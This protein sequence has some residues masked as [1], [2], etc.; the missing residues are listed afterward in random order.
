[1][2]N[3]IFKFPRGSNQSSYTK[4]YVGFFLFGVIHLSGDFM[5]ARRMIYGPFKF[6]LLQPIAI[7]LEDFV[8]YLAKRSLLLGGIGVKPGKAGGSWPP[9]VARAI[10]Y[11]WVM[12]WLCLTLPVLTGEPSTVGF[13]NFDRGPIARF[14]FDAWQRYTTH[15]VST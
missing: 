13:N 10:G 8:I 4:L 3:K 5:C 7:T 6:F 12:L 1:M 9:A 15:N 14:V 11:C 2:A